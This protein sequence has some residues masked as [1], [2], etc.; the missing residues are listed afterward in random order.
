MSCEFEVT[1]HGKW[2]LAGEHTVLRGGKAIAFPLKS[3][4]LTITFTPNQKKLSAHFYGEC[5]DDIHLLFFSVIEHGFKLSGHTINHT[6]GHFDLTNHIPIGAG[7]GASAALSL[8]VA[9]WFVSQDKIKASECLTFAQSLED[10]FHSKSSGLDI[11][12]SASDKGIL[13]QQGEFTSLEPTWSPK[14]YLSYS[15]HLGITSHCVKTVATLFDKSP[16]SAHAIDRQMNNSVDRAHHALTHNEPDRLNQLATAINQA[17][18]CFKSWGLT[19]SMLQK[20][21]DMLSENGAIAAKPTGSGSGGYVLSLWSKEPP[22]S[23][24]PLLLSASF[25]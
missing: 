16:E 12:G 20:H 21:L 17:A 22:T 14:W 19:D 8:A 7:M 13:Y 18:D 6:Q 23:L 9:K 15:G 5:A 2:I 4:K 3:K 24:K 1:T 11:V 10:L 25:A